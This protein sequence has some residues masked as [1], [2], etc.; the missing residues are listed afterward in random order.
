MHYSLTRAITWN[1]AGYLYLIIAS[2]ISIP[3]MVHSLGLAQFAQYSLIIATIVL[4][5][6]INLGLPQAVTRSLARDHADPERLNT[7][8]ATSSLLFVATGIFAGFIALALTR[9]LHLNI[10]TSAIVFATVLLNNVVTHYA[11][12][13]YAHGHFGY[14]N[15]KTFVVGTGNTLLV[16][17]LSWVGAS[18]LTILSAQLASYV[19]TLAFLTYFSLKYFKRPRAF[20]PSRQS[21]Q[22]LIAFGLKN[23]AGT[24][25]G[26]VQGQYAKFL[27]SSLS[28]LSLSAYVV[29]QGLVQKMAGGITQVATALYPASARG[30]KTEGLVRMYHALQLG[31]FG[32]GLFGVVIYHFI[33]FP[34]LTWW[35]KSSELVAVV[36]TIMQIFVWYFAILVLSPLASSIL[37]GRGRPE[38]TSLIAF[39]TTAIE[40]TLALLLF[41]HYGL[42]APVYAALI[43]ITLMTPVLLYL[44]EKVLLSANPPDIIAKPTLQHSVLRLE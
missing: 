4:V 13:P 44:V 20:T 43:A 42:M 26:Q 5:S 7:I 38:L 31:L 6:A 39:I 37:D 16:A 36:D 2:L 11:C 23:Q 18:I 21:A 30:G 32:L 24:L 25:V 15:V 12:L 19:V 40:I 33:G 14:Y 27:L 8:W 9:S 34:F 1:I 29:A 41:P 17:Y 22:A 28:P 10:L 3:I 35:L